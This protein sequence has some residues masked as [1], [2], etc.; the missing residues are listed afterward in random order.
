P[1]TIA[2]HTV[3]GTPSSLIT[4]TQGA[5]DGGRLRVSTRSLLS[6]NDG[7]SIKTT[8]PAGGRGGD[9]VVNVSDLS[10]TRGATISSNSTS[11]EVRGGDIT[12]TA[13][14]TAIISGL[15]AGRGQTGILST[16]CSCW[17]ARPGDSTLNVGTLTL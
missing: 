4:E 17:P 15:G 6:L 2:R 1:A 14:N 5:G 13:T 8:A 7:G 11:T 12:V 9:I 3:D 16:T 10:V